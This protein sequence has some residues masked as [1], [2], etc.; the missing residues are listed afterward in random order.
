[1]KQ[2]NPLKE[3]IRAYKIINRDSIIL[4][5]GVLNV[6]FLAETI[7]FH[8]YVDLQEL[9]IICSF[10]LFFAVLGY[11]RYTNRANINQR[12]IV[13]VVLYHLIFAFVFGLY[14]GEYSPYLLVWLL[15]AYTTYFHFKTRGLVAS[16]AVLFIALLNQAFRVLPDTTSWFYYVRFIGIQFVALSSISTFFA[17]TNK[18]AD[19]SQELYGENIDKAMIERQKLI[20]L[21]N[22]M[23]DGVLS[24][25]EKGVIKL[26][27]AAALNI[28]DTNTSLQDRNIKDVMN[29]IDQ[30]AKVVDVIGEI[31]SKN[32]PTTSMDHL[33]VYPNGEKINLYLNISPI[34]L[35][36]RQNTERGFII[37]FRDITREKSLE[38]ERNEFISVVSH[39]LRTPIAITEA[40][41]SNAQFI[42]EKG[43]NIE[44]VKTALEASHK[45][46][47]F[48][49]NMINDLST[50]S[51]AERGKLDMKTEVIDPHEIMK[52]LDEDYKKDAETKGL[53]FT[54]EIAENTPTSITSNRLYVREILQ[55]F[56]TNS[57]K[58]T[59]E[60]SVRVELHGEEKGIVFTVSDT[61][62]GI[63]KSDQKRVFD[64]FFR[65]E[66]FRTR[67]SSGTGL[68]LY[69]TKKL[70]K[71]ISAEIE[72]K[73]KLNEGSTFIVHIPDLNEDKKTILEN[74]PEK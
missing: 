53:A 43:N 70:M 52:S 11:M 30:S 10:S 2:Y 27:N 39:E 45:Q 69:V 9:V 35:S 42:V 7:I 61:G 8:T 25:D 34:K 38:E 64:K 71:L 29:I 33:L 72:L 14:A 63:S 46:A 50:L 67:E 12:P 13:Y 31:T 28:L 51:R 17:L 20:S 1:M 24:T 15:V 18:L 60:G 44:G 16:L 4:M 26:Y 21:I 23:G 6:L 59:K 48:L 47:L 68:G 3:S 62:I 55:N 58:Y 19:D 66:D 37:S 49:A 65:S 54:T 5:H 36:F 22:S 73:S 32:A 74:K 41:I 56:I 40:N 57:I